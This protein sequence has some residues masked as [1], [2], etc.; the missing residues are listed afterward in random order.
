MGKKKVVKEERINAARGNVPTAKVEESVTVNM[1]DYNSIHVGITVSGID[2][3]SPAATKRELA[4][5]A[6]C[7]RA[8]VEFTDQLT[9]EVLV[10]ALGEERSSDIQVTVLQKVAEAQAENAKKSKEAKAK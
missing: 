7:V 1:G 8:V 5:G 4:T 10:T 9:G 6:A 2:I 3:S